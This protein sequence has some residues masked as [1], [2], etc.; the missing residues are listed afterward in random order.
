[1]NL[2]TPAPALMYGFVN[3]TTGTHG[4][5][6]IMLKEL[7]LLFAA[8]PRPTTYEQFRAAIVGDNALLKSTET[9]RRESFRRLREL[10]GLD[11]AILLFRGLRDLWE[12]DTAAWPFLALLCALGRDALFRSTVMLLLA[13]PPGVRVTPQM[14]EGAVNDSFPNRYN[15]MTLANVGRHAASSW[16]QSGHLCGR[17][18]KTRCAAVSTPTAVTY[19]LWLGYLCGARGDGLFE[20]VWCRLLDTPRHMLHEQAAGASKLGLLEYRHTGAV[21]EITFHHLMRAPL[22]APEDAS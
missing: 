8:C 7:R 21:T 4:S 15:P 11:E 19:A 5:R 14:I 13:T 22:P 1:M 12:Q 6:T 17:T 3:E 20:T 10:Y 9:T 18:T 16:Q 2:I